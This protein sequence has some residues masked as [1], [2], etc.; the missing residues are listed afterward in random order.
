MSEEVKVT[1]DLVADVASPTEIIFEDG[2]S[3]TQWLAP[4]DL[5]LNV[6]NVSGPNGLPEVEIIGQREN[7]LRFFDE[8]LPD[9]DVTEDDLESL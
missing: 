1:T 7:V 4:Y 8:Q 6:A 5:R 3:S 2:E 9:M